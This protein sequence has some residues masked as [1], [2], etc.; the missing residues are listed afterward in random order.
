MYL[1]VDEVLDLHLLELPAPKQELPR[2]LRKKEHRNRSR[3][4]FL[5]PISSFWPNV[6]VSLSS[7]PRGDLVAE[8]LA[9]LR[10]AEGHLLTHDVGHLRQERSGGTGY[11][12]GDDGA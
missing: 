1:G 6:F 10:D 3:K 2:E 4:P 5:T 12:L 8:G 11:G 7:S 9:D